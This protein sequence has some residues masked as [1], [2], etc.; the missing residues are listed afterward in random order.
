MNCTAPE[1]VGALLA[2]A[3]TGKP[4]V[5][6]PNIGPVTPHAEEWSALGARLIGGCC[7]V[8]PGEISALRRR[9]DGG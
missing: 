9:R 6:Y 7:G 4:L 5:A 1:C 2:A 8:G 3:G